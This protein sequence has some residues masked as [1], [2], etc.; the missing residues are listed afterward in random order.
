MNSRNNL[1]SDVK[2]LMTENGFYIMDLVN[3]TEKNTFLAGFDYTT[4]NNYVDKARFLITHIVPAKTDGGRV[5]MKYLVCAIEIDYTNKIFVTSLK[6]IP[7]IV[8]EN[9][10]GETDEEIQK[11]V[12]QAYNKFSKLFVTYLQI[13][14]YINYKKDRKSMFEMCKHLDNIMLGEL[15]QEIEAKNSDTLKVMV[16]TL[17]KELFGKAI[18]AIVNQDNLV[19]RFKSLLLATYLDVMTEDEDL[20]NIA[21]NNK[22]V[23]YPTKVAFQSSNSLKGATGTS[24]ANEPVATS[25]MF[26]S[27]YTD[28]QEALELPNWSLSWFTDINHLTQST[29]VIQTSVVSTHENF[30]VT[31]INRK[32]IGKELFHHV[33]RELS[34]CRDY[35]DE[36]E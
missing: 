3:T 32:H 10:N 2:R 30:K 29:Q 34:E 26:H 4:I 1:P 9:E 27:L 24:G 8:N 12:V 36:N 16:D 15:R 22:L 11:T 23:G 20:I 21:K 13:Q 28:F 33:I 18:A 31:F 7:N 17:T 14:K 35:E 5:V 25:I 6:N 19:V